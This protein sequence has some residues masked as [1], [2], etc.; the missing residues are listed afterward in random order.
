[1]RP[2]NKR[3]TGGETTRFCLAQHRGDPDGCDFPLASDPELALYA[4]EMRTVVAT[5]AGQ[6][7]T[8]LHQMHL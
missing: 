5:H 2:G 4:D 1:V 3:D 8:M 6:L 7:D